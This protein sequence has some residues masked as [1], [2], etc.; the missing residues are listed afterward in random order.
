MV[1]NLMLLQAA[2]VAIYMLIGFRNKMAGFFRSFTGVSLFASNIQ[3]SVFHLLSRIQLSRAYSSVLK[4]L[5][6][7]AHSAKAEF[8]AL[9][10]RVFTS[11][12]ESCDNP[13]F[14]YFN[15]DNVNKYVIPRMETVGN[16]STLRSGT[17][18]TAIILED[19]P[20]G[21]F[22]R[23]PY[24]KNV[25]ARLRQNLTLD[26]LYNNIDKDHRAKVGTATI[27]RIL[28][29]NIPSIASLQQPVEK[30]FLDPEYCAQHRLRLRKTRI[31]P[32][33]TSGINEA[34]T[35]GVSAVLDDLVQQTGMK[36]DW[37]NDLLILVGGDQLSI[38][39]IRKAVYY[40]E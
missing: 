24:I 36:P 32:M 14:F 40:L 29:K 17:A 7:R 35:E 4:Y 13:E 25:E 6:K 34:T 8:K 22:K 16:K 3:K 26:E 28:T 38:D 20:P 15:F 39:R 19:V 11:T 5:T 21:A 23:D 37:F 2:T 33:G 10:K 9:G 1:H 31:H 18:A 27:M 30:L 12:D